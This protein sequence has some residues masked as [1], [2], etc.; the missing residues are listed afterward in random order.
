MNS[1]E[2]ESRETRIKKLRDRAN[3]IRAAAAKFS[4]QRAR[5]R[6]TNIAKT[7]DNTADLMERILDRRG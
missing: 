2:R 1:E 6:M 7:Y 3:E 4:D 5:E